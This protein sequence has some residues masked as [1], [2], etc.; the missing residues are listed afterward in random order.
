MDSIKINSHAKVNLNLRVVGKRPDGY[1]DILSFMQG[2]GLHDVLEI[3]NCTPNATKYNLPHC[4]IKGIVVYLCTDVETIPTDMSNLAL[5]GI[6]AVANAA[7]NNP[8]ISERLPKALLL[9]I[10]K[11]LPV[12][13]GLAGGSANAASCMLGLNAMIGSPFSLREL[14]GMGAKVGADVPFSIFMN[15]YRNASVLKGLKGLE[16][17]RDSAMTEGIGDIVTAKESVARYVILANPGTVTSTKEAYK[18]MDDIG[19]DEDPA[20]KDELFINDF[21][22]YTLKADEDAAALHKLLLDEAGAD[23][24]LMSGSGPTLAAYYKNEDKAREAFERLL[25]LT[26]NDSRIRLWLSNTGI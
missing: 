22:A 26:E 23:E 17:A 12:A 20:D 9:N 8:Q 21:E 18:A 10:E 16:E 1:H 2:V 6:E 3:K 7:S 15:A 24:V 13:A 4:N 25:K 14:M 19:F 5:K 11:K